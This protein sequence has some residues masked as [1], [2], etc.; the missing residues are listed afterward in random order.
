VFKFSKPA[1]RKKDYHYKPRVSIVIPTMNEEHVIEGRVRNIL[2]M[3]YPREKLE[4][5]FVDNSSDST[6]EIIKEYAQQ[7]PFLKLLKQEK[8]GFNNA[9]NQGYS[10][11]TGEIVIKSDCT[12]FPNPD[13]L[14]EI[15]ANFADNSIGAV[16]GVHV[17]H[18]ARMRLEREFKGIMYKTQLMES[19]FH[20]SLISHG[21]FGAFRKNLTPTLREEITADD[22]EV[23]VNVVRKGYRAII[24]TAVKIEEQA[25]ISFKER[26]SQKDRRAA[27]VIRVLLSN[28]DMVF[29]RK[30]GMFGLITMPVDLFLL[31]LSPMVLS[32]LLLM[33]IYFIFVTALPILIF[34]SFA[35]LGF[36]IMTLKFSVKAKAIFDIYMSCFFGLFQAFSKKKTWK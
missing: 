11:S 21:A 2:K 25:P 35:L 31:I 6:P 16:C 23:V 26:R 32:M 15:V 9:L 29:N 24:D 13:A 33:W 20:S 10:I 28:L 8:G 7:Y 3:K 19:Y 14:E 27:G 22:S 1:K 36:A 5:L 12:A 4:V 17:F 18:E 34:S 30:Y